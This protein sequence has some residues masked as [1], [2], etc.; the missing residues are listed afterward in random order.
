MRYNIWHIELYHGWSDYDGPEDCNVNKDIIMDSDFTKEQVKDM[1][2]SIYQDDRT[3][4]I[5]KC[6]LIKSNQ[7]L[8]LEDL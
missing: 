5:H 2:V 1:L 6:E 3:V 4:A 7:K 8:W